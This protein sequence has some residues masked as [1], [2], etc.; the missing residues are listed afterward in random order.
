MLDPYW[1]WIFISCLVSGSILAD[2]MFVHTGV[3]E[4]AEEVKKQ[5]EEFKPFIP[6]IQ[7]LR[8][9]GMRQRHWELV[10]SFIGRERFCYHQAVNFL[11]CAGVRS[12]LLTRL[13][14]GNAL[15]SGIVKPTLV[16]Q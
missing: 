10:S 12:T 13:G 7:G 16:T 8:N 4:V 15:V 9:P 2:E 5:I 6:L 14:Q 3:F 11:S 1:R